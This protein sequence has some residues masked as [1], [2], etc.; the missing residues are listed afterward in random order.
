MDAKHKL[1]QAHGSLVHYLR[2]P[3]LGHATVHLSSRLYW[4]EPIEPSPFISV[5]FRL[6]AFVHGALVLFRSID[7]SLPSLLHL[8]SKP[9]HSFRLPLIRVGAMF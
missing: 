9:D 6:I 5:V 3:R 4:N 8:Y 1:P 2:I 7:Y